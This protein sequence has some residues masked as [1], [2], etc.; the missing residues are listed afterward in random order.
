MLKIRPNA[1]AVFSRRI[2][3]DLLKKKK[4]KQKQKQKQK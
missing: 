2:S 1:A 4:K 3:L